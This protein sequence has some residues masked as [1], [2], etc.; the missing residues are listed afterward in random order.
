MKVKCNF[1]AD[2]E[3]SEKEMERISRAVKSDTRETLRVLRAVSN[4][5]RLKILRSLTVKEQCVC[6]FV[7]MLKV[8]YSKLSYHLNVLKGAGLVES[9]KKENFLIYNVTDFGKKVLKSIER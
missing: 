7:S 1:P 8:N 2:Y 4:Q 9:V 6:V 3:I 5:L